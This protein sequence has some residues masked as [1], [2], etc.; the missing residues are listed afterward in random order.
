[1]SVPVV[2]TPCA[3]QLPLIVR[4]SIMPPE[5]TL[6]VAVPEIAAV[7]ELYPLTNWLIDEPVPPEGAE[8]TPAVPLVLVRICQ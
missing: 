1:M 5:L 6:T 2:V 4:K 7:P 3:S 8:K